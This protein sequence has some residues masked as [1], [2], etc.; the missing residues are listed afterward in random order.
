MAWLVAGVLVLEFIY[1]LYQR[2]SMKAPA[3]PKPNSMDRPTANEGIPIPVVFG[4]RAVKNVNI[5]WCG[6]K[7]VT[8]KGA[9]PSTDSSVGYCYWAGMQIMVCHGK[10]DA[11]LD[12]YY[13]DKSCAPKGLVTQESVNGLTGVRLNSYDG[14]TPFDNNTLVPSKEGVFGLAALNDGAVNNAGIDAGVNDY[15][16]Q[17]MSLPASDG[18]PPTLDTALGPKYYGIASAVL[19]RCLFGPSP[20]LRPISFAVKRIHTRN[21]GDTQW[22]DAKAE[23][24]P[25]TRSRQD[26]WKYLVVDPT[27]GYDYSSIT[28]DDSAWAQGHGGIGNAPV[29][30][31]AS[32][33]FSVGYTWQNYAIPP[34]GTRLPPD[35]TLVKVDSSGSGGY[36]VKEGLKLWLRWDMGAIPDYPLTV[37]CWHDDSGALWFNEHKITLTPVVSTSNPEMGHYQSTAVI[38]KEYINEAGPNVVAYRVTDTYDQSTPPKKIGSHIFIYAGIQIG[39]DAD[40]PAGL[41]DMNPAHVIHEV[42]TDSLWGMG[43]TDADLDDDSFK[44][45]ADTLFAEGLGISFVWSQQMA[46]EDFLADVLHHISGVLYIDRTTG[47]FVLKLL[48]EDYTVG[49]LLV[50]DESCVSKIEEATRKQMGELVNTVTVTYTSTVQGDSGSV[51]LFDEG[52]VAAQGGYVSSKIDY[53]MV[54]SP[55]NAAK[56]ALRDLR[57]LSSPLLACTVYAARQAAGLNIGDPFVLNWPDLGINSFVMRVT[58]IDLGDG[59]SNQVKVSC[60]EDVFFFPSQAIT[61]P[62]DT[63][64]AGVVTKPTPM[65]DV[66][67]YVTAAVKDPRGIGEVECCFNAGSWGEAGCLTGWTQTSEGVWQRDALGPLT[68]TMFD[69]IN[70][71][72]GGTGSGTGSGE[73][74]MVGRTFFV[75]SQDGDLSGK[76]DQ[77]PYVLDDPG[78]YWSGGGE[79]MFVST[80]ARMHRD[81]S[82]NQSENFVKDMVLRVRNGTV[83]GGHYL[84]LATDNVVL[85]TTDMN[86]QDE[87]ASFTFSDTLALLRSDQI[88]EQNVSPDSDLA[89]SCSATNGAEAFDGFETLVDTPGSTSIPAGPWK[90]YPPNCYITGGDVGST[91]TL[92]FAF[93]QKKLSG[94]VSLF[95]ILTANIDWNEAAAHAPAPVAYNAPTYPLDDT[96]RLSLIPTI[97]TDSTT[98]VTMV[99]DYNG[100]N[101]IR[102]E[103]PRAISTTTHSAPDEAW[104]DITIVDGV[105]SDFGTHRRLRVH[106][107]GPLVGIATTGLVGG[108]QLMLSFVDGLTITAAGSPSSGAAIMTEKQG[109]GSYSGNDLG[110]PVD[111]VASV[112]LITDS[113]SATFWK[114]TGG[115]TG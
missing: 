29:G 50:L 93:L 18:S 25:G 2:W 52:M 60:V 37:Q 87:G 89:L 85:G 94:D 63:L 51:T 59:V 16:A 90:V 105:I 41:V 92:G 108:V 83:Y 104:Y 78:G 70:P 114:Y 98:P 28:L 91:T 6:D 96:D 62:N 39:V 48:R 14:S 7:S 24:A 97:H 4:S 19:E 100:A 40:T 35:G 5:T 68:N 36:E 65:V 49:D 69:G 107:A 73:Q 43:Y 47:L 84:Q 55:V 3:A 30:F 15:L 66:D 8:G 57:I 13:A 31:D 113:G 106:G 111:S 26:V 9:M 102:V 72:T 20:F 71:F 112:A 11:W 42:L 64:P 33:G 10:I 115:S 81:P 110:C 99:I 22:Y 95:E 46:I 12:A 38:P 34:T 101:A 88:A 44:A 67:T 27:D 23:I 54:T 75:I 1:S 76:P 58:S 56:L 21:G 45:A 61:M 17:N 53:P 103:I 86:W 109:T 82:F 74:W 32:S 77:G 80:Y 79:P